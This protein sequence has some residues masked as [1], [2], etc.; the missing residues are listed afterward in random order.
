MRNVDDVRVLERAHLLA[1]SAYR[2]SRE[3]PRV[4][5][6]GLR[7]QMERAA[8]SVAANI[9]EGLGRG[10]QGDVERFLRIAAGSAVEMAALI[11]IADELYPIEGQIIDSVRE[12]LDAVRRM[13]TRFVVTVREG[14]RRPSVSE[15][16]LRPSVE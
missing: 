6:F 3:L 14:R 5:M 13:L 1:L 10:T 16:R 9:A 12:H 7:S 4:E 8:V 11:R 15:G 2:V